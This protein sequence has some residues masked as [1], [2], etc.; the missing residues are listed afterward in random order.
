MS[1]GS[2][3]ISAP[4]KGDLR[5]V[6]SPVIDSSSDTKR[7]S[8]QSLTA[9]GPLLEAD[10]TSAGFSCPTGF[11]EHD[12]ACYSVSTT[13]GSNF[14]A[15]NSACASASGGGRLASIETAAQWTGVTA[16][17]RCVCVCVCVCVCA[18]VRM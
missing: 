12:S 6:R 10:A 4:L 3:F 11:T 14:N 15:A 16:G 13:T 18:C 7:L 9:L 5:H 8:S 2:L 17:L 1:L